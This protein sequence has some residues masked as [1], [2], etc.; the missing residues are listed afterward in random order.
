[1]STFSN[2]KFELIGTGD[3][4]GTWGV[5]TNSNIGT[6]IEQAIVG[7][8][9]PEYPSDANLTISL[10]N[11]VALQDARALVLNVTSAVSLTVT[12]ELVVPT[13][14]KQ[15][16]VQNNTTGSQSIT[17][18]TSAGSGITVPNGRKA[19]LY[20]NGTDVIQMFDFVDI[21]GG[22]IDGT[23][24]GAATPSTGAFTT[25]SASGTPTLSGLT[26]STA[27]ALDAS[28]NVVSVT[29]TGT[30]NNVLAT[31]PTLVTPALGTPSALTL[32]NATG[33]P[34][35]T[36]I[37]GLGSGVATFLATPSS[38]NLAAAVTDETGSGAVVFATSPTL[39]TP[40]LGTPTSATLTN[41]TGLPVSTGISG[42]GSGV[43]TFLATPSSANLAAAVSDE[44]GSGAVVF[45]TSPTLVTPALGTPSSATLTNATGLPVSTGISGLGSGVATFLA[46]P[47][48]ANL[49]AAVSDETGSGALVFATSPTLVTPALGTP[50]SATLTNATGL[51][52]ST[53]ISGLGS[54]VATALAA[55]ANSSTGPVTGGGTA[56]LSSKRID[57]RVSSTA[58]TSTLTPDISA[59][60][61]YNLTAQA[62]SL[63]IAA[64]TGTPVDGNRLIIRLFDNG[65][66]RSITWNGTYTAIGVTLPP[67]TTTGKTIYVG[68]VYN[69][70]ATRWDV[71]AVATQA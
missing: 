27:L 61:Q 2:L 46:T 34:V 51:P 4:S 68:C 65:T 54:G 13:I 50:T 18:K 55:T 38:A 28:K 53:G 43:A 17:V 30:G 22:A 35:S 6:A 52:V 3:Q 31:S 60:D 21:N 66:A 20:V 40:A 24:V 8:A 41:A 48:S 1:M 63:T 12:R 29:N 58:S 11:T 36:G 44:T 67:S 7:L 62:A 59:F 37:S 70:A 5:T 42:L 23:S 69:A 9:N 16:I 15:Y 49:A 56:T 71:V 32:T 57:P 19:H 26:A 39:V 10:T 25:L 33:L 64:P 47:S 45:A 14:Q